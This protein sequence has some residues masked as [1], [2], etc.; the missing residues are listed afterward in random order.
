[1]RQR[2]RVAG[3]DL[4]AVEEGHLHGRLRQRNPVRRLP[5]HLDVSVFSGQPLLGYGGPVAVRLPAGL[6]ARG[7]DQ[8]FLEPARRDDTGESGGRPGARMAPP[9]RGGARSHNIC[10]TSHTASHARPL[11][12]RL[13]SGAGR[14]EIG[15][16]LRHELEDFGLGPLGP[17]PDAMVIRVV[18]W[19]KSAGP[20]DA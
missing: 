20:A 3:S 10:S 2:A 14:P 11:L 6:L 17:R 16:F 15:E 1:M 4:F 12:Q 8:D 7:E 9:D 18:D 5:P 13:R 19:W